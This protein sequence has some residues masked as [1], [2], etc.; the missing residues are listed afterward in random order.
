LAHSV[1]N[2]REIVPGLITGGMELSELD[3]ANRMGAS[4]GGM[5]G[6]GIKAGLEAIKLFDS[7]DIV[8]GEVM[9]PAQVKL[10]A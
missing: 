3:G 5:F 4:F 7:Y 6:S 1:N 10:S 8:E 9:G 2:T